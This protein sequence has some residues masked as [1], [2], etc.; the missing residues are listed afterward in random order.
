MLDVHVTMFPSSSDPDEAGIDYCRQYVAAQLAAGASPQQILSSFGVEAAEAA[1]IGDAAEAAEGQAGEALVR[2]VL[3]QVRAV[4]DEALPRALMAAVHAG[5]TAEALALMEAGAPWDAI[6]SFGHSAGAIALRDGN[7]ALLDALLEAGSSSVLWEVD[8]ASRS[9]AVTAATDSGTAA[10]RDDAA[11]TAGP[12]EAAHE[13]CFGHS[14]HSDFL[15]QRL[16]FE[17]GRLM[18]ELDRPVMMAWEAPLMEAHAAALCPEEGG[19]RVLN[20]GF[21]LGLVD[22]ALQRRR[23]ASHTIVEPHADVLLAMRRGG[24]LERAG[25]TVLQGTW[26]GVLPPLCDEAD[27]PF[28]AIFFDTFAEGGACSRALAR[29]GRGVRRRAVSRSR[30]ALPLPR[31][32]ARP[33]PARRSLLV[34]QRHRLARRLPAPRLLRGRTTPPAL[35]RPDR[36]LRARPGVGGAGHVGGRRGRPQLVGPRALLPAGVREAAEG[37]GGGRRLSPTCA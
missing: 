26:Q 8:R 4:Q 31:A 15:Q 28:D 27:P 6:D 30:R 2:R 7:T 16:R 24:W 9:E 36:H 5:Q 3:A 25:V 13:A 35:A 23:P 29:T 1:T 37:G 21:G 33:A 32:A 20:L 17:E 34:L 18:D 11:A 19:A 12:A 22:T 14:L 10:D